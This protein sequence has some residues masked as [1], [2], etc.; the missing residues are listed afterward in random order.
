MSPLRTCACLLLAAAAMLCTA[1]PAHADDARAGDAPRRVVSMNLCTDQLAILM[2]APGQLHSV[3]DLARDARSSVLASEAERFVVNHGLAEE[4]FTM[5]PDLVLAGT[6]TSRASVAM[7]KRLGFR[8]EEFPPAGTFGEI[9]DQIR[10]MGRLLGRDDRAEELAAEL[11]RRLAAI[12]APVAGEKRP[13]VA[14]H[15]EQSYTAGSGTLASEIV[16]RAGAENLG[17]RL[18]L[19]GTVRMPLE[20]LVLAAPDLVVG[21][22]RTVSGPA[23]AYETFEHPA[24]RA[25]IRGRE[26]IFIPDKY[27]V[28]GAPFTAEAVRI[29]AEAAAPFRTRGPAKP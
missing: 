5:Q 24:L 10:R 22:S 4:I 7:L 9:R 23:L 15:Y 8:V 28:C 25:V 14:L 12:P 1:A 3:S 11:D 19:E 18:G 27:W 2:A 13:L 26:M 21:T 16:T 17:S 29:L 20:T 6:F